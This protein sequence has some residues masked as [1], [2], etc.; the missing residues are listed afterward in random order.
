MFD[1]HVYVVEDAGNHG[2]ILNKIDLW[3]RLSGSTGNCTGKNS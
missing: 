1:G 3:S 2:K